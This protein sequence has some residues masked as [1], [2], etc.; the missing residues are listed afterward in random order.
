MTP[1]PRRN[2]EQSKVLR[3]VNFPPIQRIFE[4]EMGR[5]MTPEEKRYFHID[6]AKKKNSPK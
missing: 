1:R 5:K 2:R 4:Q 3:S 6:P